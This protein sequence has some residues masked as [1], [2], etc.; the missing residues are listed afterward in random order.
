MSR[1]GEAT[2]SGAAAVPGGTD[3]SGEAAVAELDAHLRA[4]AVDYFSD[5][6]GAPLSVVLL[7]AQVRPFSQLY[8]FALVAGARER[9][10][11]IK[12][13]VSDPGPQKLGSAVADP[14]RQDAR[15]EARPRL[16]PPCD[17]AL[18]CVVEHAALSA[19]ERHFASLGDP[20]FGA[21]RVLALL[22]E[23]QAVL[24]ERLDQ[25]SL[26]A[27][28]MPSV[29]LRSP[30]SLEHLDTAFHNAGAWLRSYHSMPDTQHTPARH[31]TRTE[32]LD[33]I[34]R[35]SAYLGEQM[36][37]A[38]F[39]HRLAG[40]TAFEAAQVLPD[41]LPLGLSHGDYAL[42]NVL[43]GADAGVTLCDTRSRWRTAVFED[44]GYFLV[45]LKHGWPQLYTRGL[46]LRPDRLAGH[47][48]Q[49]LDGY[50]QGGDVPVRAVRL[51]EIM[52][53]LD[54]TAALAAQH[55]S[56][57]TLPARLKCSIQLRLLAGC[58]RRTTGDL[59]RVGGAAA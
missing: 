43:V 47:E 12:T 48:R 58:I 32:F 55:A 9:R 30:A 21:I 41:K 11:L 15:S 31:A 57:S 45:S 51:Y 44:I 56:A 33:F 6:A 27:L 29:R 54:R 39:F 25:S 59:I 24:M 19:I 16:A 8:E 42:R 34:D 28:L 22:S 1:E 10:V 23:P 14:A 38:S 26:R 3:M 5:L 46:V 20:R 35:V 52:A 7:G 17:P 40:A 18:S 13:A 36:H 53:L 4:H 37:S 50:F 49:F 2:V